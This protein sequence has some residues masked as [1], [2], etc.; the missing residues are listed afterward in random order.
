MPPRGE[1]PEVW[2]AGSRDL[3]LMLGA[4]GIYFGF[5]SLPS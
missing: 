3:G 5:D 4:L 2:Q 1:A